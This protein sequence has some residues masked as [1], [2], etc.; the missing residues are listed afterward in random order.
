MESVAT[1]R[2]GSARPALCIAAPILVAT[3][4]NAAATLCSPAIVVILA[5]VPITERQQSKAWADIK[6]SSDNP[7]HLPVWQL[8]LLSM[9]LKPSIRQC[10]L[11]FVYRSR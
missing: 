7:A 2:T 1:A 4:F 10:P 5:I 3:S 6:L 11:A 9:H 8:G